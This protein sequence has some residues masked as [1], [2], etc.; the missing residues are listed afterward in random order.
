MQ[1]ALR[2]CPFFGTLKAVPYISPGWGPRSV[3]RGPTL[4]NDRKKSLSSGRPDRLRRGGE[5]ACRQRVHNRTLRRV[6]ISAP[7]RR[8]RKI[9]QGWTAFLFLRSHPGEK[10]PNNIL[11]SPPLVAR[12]T[13]SRRRGKGEEE[14]PKIS[15]RL[16]QPWTHAKEL[17]PSGLPLSAALAFSLRA[18]SSRKGNGFQIL[19]SELFP[20]S[21]SDRQDL[22]PLHPSPLKR[23]KTFGLSPPVRLRCLVS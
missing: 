2:A 9:A 12:P 15:A 7:R 5:E 3:S 1:I 16:S 13:L 19:N 23:P 20:G 4:G 22:P 14:S 6:S 21:A 8:C 11:P 18:L 17:S 10:H